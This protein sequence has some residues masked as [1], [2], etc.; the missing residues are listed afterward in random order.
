M[1]TFV[2]S[3]KRLFSRGI[4]AN[5]D[6]EKLYNGGKISADERDFILESA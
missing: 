2:E 5:D 3:L 4:L 1:N 6:I